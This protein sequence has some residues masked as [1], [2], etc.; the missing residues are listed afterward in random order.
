MATATFQG[1]AAHGGGLRVQV[2]R[3]G[4]ATRAFGQYVT[5]N[6]F[7]VLQVRPTYGRVFTP[8]DDL[9]GALLV[10]VLDFNYWQNE[11]NADPKV[12][13]LFD[14]IPFTIARSDAAG[15]LR[16]QARYTCQFVGSPSHARAISPNK[17]SQ[18]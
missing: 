13:G 3:N 18:L 17:I 5:G 7:S 14:K 6:F 4:K 11:L 10:V 2:D 1:I 15:I 12:V 16:H 8:A 9:P